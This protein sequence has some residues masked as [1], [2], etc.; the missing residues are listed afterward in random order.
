MGLVENIIFL[1]Y[2]AITFALLNDH[3]NHIFNYSK[4]DNLQNYLLKFLF[5]VFKFGSKFFIFWV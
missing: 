1:G 5:S 2:N 4:I 3:R